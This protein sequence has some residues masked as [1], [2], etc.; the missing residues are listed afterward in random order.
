MENT[1]RKK[2]YISGRIKGLNNFETIFKEAENFLLLFG[3]DVINPVTLGINL[4]AKIGR[5]PT[6]KEYMKED[7]KALLDCDIIFM[8][9]NWKKS[10]GAKDEK[11]V[12]EITGI[13][14][15]YLPK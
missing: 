6:Y 12:A 9:P 10:K 14:I 1:T 7:L 5:E 11:R 8:L 15:R 3:Y 2:G 4:E 13:E